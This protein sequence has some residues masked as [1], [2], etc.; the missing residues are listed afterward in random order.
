MK[1]KYD[2]VFSFVLSVAYALRVIISKMKML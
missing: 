2:L 1:G